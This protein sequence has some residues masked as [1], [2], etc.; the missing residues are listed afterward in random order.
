MKTW[1]HCHSDQRYVGG[2]FIDGYQKP[3]LTRPKLQIIAAVVMGA[4]L[5][6]SIVDAE[7]Q[8]AADP[9][10]QA[11]GYPARLIRVIMP[12][13]AG[14]GVDLFARILGKRLQDVFGQNVIVDNRSGAGGN[15]GAELVAKSVPDGYT[16]MLSSAAVAISATLYSKLA[17]D[18][19]RD[20]TPVTQILSAPLVVAVHPS[21][22]ARSVKELVALSKKNK[23]GMNYGSAGVGT[24]SHL[25]GVM[26]QQSAGIPLT[27]VPYS[28]MPPAMVALMSGQVEI[29][30]PGVNS[31]QPH[32]R[33]GKLRALAVTTLAR[34]PALPDLPTLDSYYAGFDIDNWYMLFAPAGTPSAIVN[35]LHAEVFRSLQ[36]PEIIAFLQG[37]GAV[38]VGSAPAEAATFFKREIGN[39][40]KIVRASGAKA[41]N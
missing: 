16:L 24:A 27:H 39:Y 29:L 31:V 3:R 6:S 35:R 4:A 9:A 33:S 14:G 22:P 28:G 40:A 10:S 26:L 1:K 30:F 19:G 34:S 5:T 11:Q 41:E 32:L 25:A 7:A 12:F 18:P 15:I 13:A 8:T 2:E 23:A 17:Y 36:H 21:L 38:P 37:E 20:L